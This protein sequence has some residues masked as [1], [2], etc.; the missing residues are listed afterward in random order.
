MWLK[1]KE[2]GFKLYSCSTEQCSSV[3]NVSADRFTYEFFACKHPFLWFGLGLRK[4]HRKLCVG[5]TGVPVW[6]KDCSKLSC[7]QNTSVSTIGNG[8]SFT[9]VFLVSNW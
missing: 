8:P 2:N 1:L 9:I 5:G 6:L 3:E 4:V 7:F